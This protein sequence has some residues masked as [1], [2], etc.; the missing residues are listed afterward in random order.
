MHRPWTVFANVIPIFHVS[1]LI[2][3]FVMFQIITES[4]QF[5]LSF[6]AAWIVTSMMVAISHRVPLRRFTEISRRLKYAAVRL[7]VGDPGRLGKVGV[8][9]VYSYW[10]GPFEFSESQGIEL[11]C[12][13]APGWA[14]SRD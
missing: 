14:R 5:E 1:I 13:L 10:P 7:S 6:D 4:I 12:W 3:I 2:L 11:G 8:W 9:D